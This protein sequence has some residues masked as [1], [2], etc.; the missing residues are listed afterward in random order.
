[1]ILARVQLLVN[2]SIARHARLTSPDSECLAFLAH[3]AYL[4]QLAIR[5]PRILS[6]SDGHLDSRNPLHVGAQITETGRH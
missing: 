5:W 6:G 1:M 2:V 4:A 3:P